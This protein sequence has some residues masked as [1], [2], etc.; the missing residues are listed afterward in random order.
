MRVEEI[1]VLGSGKTD[2]KAVKEIAR[3]ELSSA[4]T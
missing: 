2:L 4:A 3:N 1:A